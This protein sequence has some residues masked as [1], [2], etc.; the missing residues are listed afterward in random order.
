[1]TD[2]AAL[3]NSTQIMTTYTADQREAVQAFMR[4]RPPEFTER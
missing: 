4:K 3:E 2:V 1:M